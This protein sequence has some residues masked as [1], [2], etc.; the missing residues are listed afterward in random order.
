MQH[1]FDRGA[2][3]LAGLGDVCFARPEVRLVDAG[4]IWKQGL[5]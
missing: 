2:T 5:A 4:A 1:G 3:W